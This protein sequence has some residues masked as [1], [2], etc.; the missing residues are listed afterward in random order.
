ME[1]F[2][3]FIFIIFFSFFSY[4]LQDYYYEPS[5]II[6]YF[7]QNP[8]SKED[9][10]S[11]IEYISN[12]FSEAY[13]FN[14]IAKNPPQP[15]FDSNYHKSVDIQK[16][17]KQINVENLTN[18]EFFRNIS[19]VLAD[20]KD[21]HIKMQWNKFKFHEFNILAPIEFYIKEY[22]N[23]LRVFGECAEND[24]ISLFL[25]ADEIE[26]LCSFY[27]SDYPIASI[28]DMDPFEW[29]S[30]FGGNFVSTKNPQAT[31]SFKLRYHNDVSL[32]EYPFSLEELSNFKV[33]FEGADSF[34]TDYVIYSDI[35]LD[36][37]DNKLRNLNNKINKKKV[38]NNTN[39]NKLKREKNKRKSKIRKL[40]SE[41][42]WDYQYKDD[43]KCKYDSIN[44]V[45]IYFIS[46]FWTENI[47][48]YKETITNCYRLFD[49]NTDPIIVINDLNN[50]GYISLSQLLLGI[51]SP[52]TPLDL[53]KGRFRITDNFKNTD[54]ISEFLTTNF[55]NIDTCKSENFTDLINNKVTVDRGNGI[56]EELSKIFL[57]SNDAYHDEIE[58]IRSEMKNKR[59]PT[60]IIVFTDG[61][62]LSSAAFFVKYLQNNG[63][64]IVVGYSG[65]PNIDNSTVFDSGQS[66]SPLFNSQIL[67]L[68][69][70]SY[71]KLVDKYDIELE[72]P[73]IQSFYDTSNYNTPIE[74]SVTPVDEKVEIYEPFDEYSYDSFISVSKTIL[75]KYKTSCNPDNRNLVKIDENCQFKENYTHGGHICDGGV[76][77][78]EC[79]ASYC[80]EGYIFDKNNKECIIDVCSKND[81]PDEPDDGKGKGKNDNLLFIV[82]CISACLVVVLAIFCIVCCICRRKNLNSPEIESIDNYKFYEN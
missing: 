73:G 14:E 69:S 7:N 64:G 39:I 38:K 20:L 5:Q 61:Y 26:E 44:N 12:T 4:S 79:V 22:E 24:V 17:L 28:N 52:L 23:E 56:K 25:N 55:T 67:K 62:T 32:S 78:N 11:I 43:L 54:K 42:D 37:E 6:D 53:Y 60:D 65:N 8:L 41:I 34:T 3:Y 66:A 19:F 18:Y 82:I 70:E 36:V 35:D 58:K 33:E 49:N 1:R 16:N 50:G 40:E 21:G 46:T 74:Y 9:K 29:I 51:V 45:N 68:F 2:L 57:L 15:D 59:K 47:P 77:G 10:E 75:E 76:W 13:A 80:D 71:N 48:E 72:M 27:S 81:V 63:G 31:F 30:N